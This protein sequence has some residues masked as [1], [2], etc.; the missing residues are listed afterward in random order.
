MA[1][2]LNLRADGSARMAYFGATPWHRLGTPVEHAMTS[3]EAWRLAGLDYITEL[4]SMVTLSGLPVSGRYAVVRADTRDVL[5]T[6][7]GGYRPIQNH[8]AFG[9]LDALVAEGKLEYHTAGALGLGERVWMLAKL[10]G[11]IVVKDVDLTDKYLLLSN[12]HDGQ[13]AMR[14][15]YT[16]IRVVCQ[17]TL[18]R[19]T[20]LA[21][22][23]GAWIAHRGDLTAK[24]GEAQRLLGLAERF[25]DDL[26]E[27]ITRLAN[28]YPTCPQ[29]RAFIAELYPD[30]TPR[31]GQPEA[32]D[33]AVK[34]VVK[35]R[36]AIEGLFEGGLGN[37]EDGIRH[38]GWALVNAVTEYVDHHR[39]GSGTDDREKQKK[40]L[41]ANWFG[42]GAA[43]KSEAFDYACEMA[44]S[45]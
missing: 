39:T 40:R 10:P 25:Y 33:R 20:R 35:T 17:N 1:H 41:E 19:A 15:H 11:S 6:V 5:G 44:M 16:A 21:G 36:A 3:E 29:V 34:A 31:D 23:G 2:E 26:E 22:D 27:R 18:S 38:T 14:V 4:E 42:Q 24:F 7:G 28:F 8:E 45:N 9:F 43:L 32:T 12:S 37:A 30:P 13:Q